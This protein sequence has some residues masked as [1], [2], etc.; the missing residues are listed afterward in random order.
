[1]LNHFSYYLVIV[2]KM[3]LVIVIVI[4]TKISLVGP[5]VFYAIHSAIK[6]HSL[7]GAIS[8]YSLRVFLSISSS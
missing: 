1:M 8:H 3:F 7:G 4:V 5:V 2:M 6:K